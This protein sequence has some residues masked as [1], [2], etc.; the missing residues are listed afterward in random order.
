MSSLNTHTIVDT[1]LP[2]IKGGR[3]P[4]RVGEHGGG[5]MNFFSVV[6]NYNIDFAKSEMN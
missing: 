4:F 1:R 2:G 5:V 3:P 6:G